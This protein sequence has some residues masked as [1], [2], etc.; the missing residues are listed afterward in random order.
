MLKP[1]GLFTFSHLLHIL[2]PIQGPFFQE[3]AQ[4]STSLISTGDPSCPA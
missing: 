2:L 1:S 3:A 4:E